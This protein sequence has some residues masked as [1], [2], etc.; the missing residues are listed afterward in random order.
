MR[1]KIAFILMALST[2][3]YATIN[4][5][6][7]KPLSLNEKNG[8]LIFK[9]K[10]AGESEIKTLEVSRRMECLASGEN[11]GKGTK[12]EF[13][14]AKELLKMYTDKGDKFVFGHNSLGVPEKPDRF[15]AVNLKVFTESSGPAIVWSVNSNVGS[16]HCKYKNPAPL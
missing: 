6:E 16:H 2:Y 8:Y 11:P 14:N 12:E 1:Y 4:F 7:V 10:E 13:D 9:F 15:W 5:I 3:C